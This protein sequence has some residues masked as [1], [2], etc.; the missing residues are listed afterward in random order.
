MV[1]QTEL[2][3]S[4][5]EPRDVITDSSA[6]HKGDIGIGKANFTWSNEPT[7]G[8]ATPSRQTF[9]L[10]IDDELQFQRGGFNL[11]VGPTGSGKTSLLMALLGEMHYIPQSQALFAYFGGI[12]SLEKAQITFETALVDHWWHY[13]TIFET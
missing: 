11:I 13:E 9:R 5:A 3:D 2:L 7:D 10:R 4:F 1:Y 8:S 12:S 6:A